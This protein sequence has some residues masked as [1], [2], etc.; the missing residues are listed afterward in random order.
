MK[1]F[2]SIIL[3]ILLAFALVSCAKAQTPDW[4]TSLDL[5]QKYLL[6]GNYEQAIIEFNKVIE[7]DPKNVEA[8]IGLAEVYA[9]QGDYDSAIS[10]LEQGYAE[11]G[12]QSLQDKINELR[13]LAAVQPEPETTA[14]PE[15]KVTTEAEITTD[16]ETTLIFEPDPVAEDFAWTLENGVLT[17]SGH[18]SMPDYDYF[19][20]HAPWF[21]ERDDIF[22]IIVEEGITSVSREAFHSC[23][24]CTSVNLPESITHIEYG[25]FIDCYSLES[26]IIPNNVRSIGECA[27]CRCDS[28]T[29]VSLPSS[30]LIIE[31]KAF[32]NC[33]SLTSIS[34]PNGVIS[35][36]YDAFGDCDVLSEIVIPSSVS[37]IE[38]NPFAFCYMLKKVIVEND[39]QNY[40]SIDNVL[41]SEDSTVL[42][43]YPPEK[44]VEQYSIPNGVTSIADCA[45]H[46]C[47]LKSITVPE[48]VLNIGNCA[49]YVCRNL[50]SIYIPDNVVNIGNDAFFGCENLTIY[51]KSGSYA[52]KYA[53]ENNIPFIVE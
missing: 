42:I 18:G 36:G 20:N 30:I 43:G 8:Y 47:N 33:D 13:G 24:Y 25:A 28:L 34:M 6:D 5:G 53:L 19:S 23:Y 4:Q 17:L 44:D 15:V 48:S 45:F 21:E 37:F 39:N 14:T 16:A 1:K 12:N 38:G 27:F 35:I 49:F 10:V 40:K 32:V 41:F 26:I 46:S 50:T 51:G 22:Q 9:A 52:E 7:I 3:T 29:S 11:T 2:M 31:A